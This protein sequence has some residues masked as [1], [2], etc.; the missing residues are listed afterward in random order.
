[1][2]EFVHLHVHTQ[3]SLLDGLN[4][5][6]KLFAK[7][8]ENGMD[9]VAISDHGVLYGVPEFWTMSKEFGVKPILGCEMYLSPGSMELRQ[10]IDGLKYYHLLLIAKNKVG[11]NN[12]IK[13]VSESHLRGMYYKPRVDIETLQKYSEGL[14][15]TSACLAGPLATHIAR[16]E[17]DKAEEWL[18]KLHFIFK[19]DFYL[20]IQRNG[21][22]CE[23]KIDEPLIR[24]YP[25]IEQEEHLATVKLQ[26]KVNQKLYDYSK[27]FNIPIVAT[28]DAHYLDK[29]DK[30]VQK[31]LF[32]IK[33]GKGLDDPTAMNG[34]VETYIKT[35]EELKADFADIPEVLLET[36]K[37]GE[38]IEA[39]D[40]KYDRVQPK[41][42]NIPEGKTSQ[43]ILQDEVYRGALSKYKHELKSDRGHETWDMS[44]D[45]T[46]KSQISSPKSHVSSLTADQIR[47][48]F[49]KELSERLDY[50]LQV[51]HDKGFDDYFLV[52]SDIMKWSAQ[53]NILTGVRG[54]VAGSAAA[55]CLDIVE[56][57]PIKWQLYFERFLNPERPSPPDIDMDIQ[58]SRRDELIDYVK[59]KYGVEAVAA[60]CAIGRLKTKAAIRDVGRV[61][62][63][64]LK[65][66]DRLSKMVIVLFGKP[67]KFD[68]MMELDPEFKAIVEADPKLIELGKIV[69][70]IEGLSRHMSVHACGHLITPGPIVDYCAL[71]KETGGERVITQWEGPW[72]EE[73]GLMKF[74]FLGLRT[75]TIISDT[76]ENIKRSKGEDV[77]INFYNMPEGDAPTY[78]LLGRG[79][80]IGVFQFESPPMQKYLIDLQPE[81]QEDLCFMAAAYRPGPMKYIPDYIKCKHGEKEPEFIVDDLKDIIG[82]T[83][84][85]AI[86]Q[87]QVIKIAVDLAG[88]SMGGADIL[89]RAM[90]KKKKD[91][92]EKEEVIFKEG[93][94]KRGYGEDVA[95]KLWEYLL[96]FADYGFNKAH[97][98]GYAVLAYKCAYLKAHYPL[99][100]MT[101]LMHADIGTPD[102]IVIDMKEAGRLGFSILQP[103]INKSFVYFTPEGE[104]GIRFGLGAIKNVGNRVCEAIVNEREQNGEFLHLDDLVRRV[105]PKELSKKAVEYLIKAGA[106]DDFGDRAALITIIPEVF[107]K[108]EKDSRAAE[109]G[110]ADLFG[111][112]TDI[113]ADHGLRLPATPFPTFTPASDREKMEW[114]RELLGM[115]V[116]THPLQK[117]KWARV[118]NK[119]IDCDKVPELE[120]QQMVKIL[121]MF[122]GIRIVH[123]KKD[124]SRMA[125]MQIEDATGTANGVIF[126]KTFEKLE[127]LGLIEENR[128]YIITGQ[129]NDRED[130]RSVIVNEIEPANI[131]TEPKEIKIDIR[132]IH[133]KGD[134]E[135]LSLVLKKEPVDNHARINILYG[136]SSTLKEMIRY[137]DIQS[138]FNLEVLSQ[139]VV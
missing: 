86:Y 58:D 106:L 41:F 114:E 42:W 87:E 134:I 51:I 96:P 121:G 52:V 122:T 27:Q 69:K 20:E 102:R 94:M 97:A 44:K 82:Y 117:F 98:A 113:G 130:S 99:E 127:K 48:L 107:A 78:E 28:T 76:L 91:V 33:D 139:W 14:I 70:K 84:G 23:D 67:K 108:C 6:E 15:C 81:S 17:F 35:P 88:Y 92:M 57:D 72:I 89:R 36:V 16:D 71:Q 101:A 40:I 24:S 2:S 77:D 123:T 66:A 34:Y 129:V 93:V 73:L 22:R 95:R 39:F 83:Y 120:N 85:F 7:V 103:S 111:T 75:L 18:K 61:M 50:E 74:D 100:F 90:G 26:V 124:N 125:V 118:H 116:T 54:S 109:L 79:E 10:E 110:Q 64:D 104:S 13:L 38:K 133:E 45:P 8:K 32:C 43:Q 12:L 126:P 30:D 119:I 68:E 115:F 60:I 1:M 136:T 63:V 19:D 105:G 132:N 62:G 138:D 131:M 29:S 3:Y 9:A 80:T 25:Q 21:I 137:A 11:Y 5:S 37:V 53:N 55:H 128:P 4:R 59:N 112:I 135:K 49:N 65:I 56:I 46:L 47:P 31:I